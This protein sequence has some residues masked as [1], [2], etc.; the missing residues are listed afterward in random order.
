MFD[1]TYKPRPFCTASIEVRGFNWFGAPRIAHCYRMRHEPENKAADEHNAS[2]TYY[3]L[4]AEA[5]I[6]DADLDLLPELVAIP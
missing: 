3:A 2:L 5:G 6:C 4:E 1:I